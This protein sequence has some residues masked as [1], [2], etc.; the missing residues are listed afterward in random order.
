MTIRNCWAA[1]FGTWI[2]SSR[3][4]VILH[5]PSH[6]GLAIPQK[7]CGLWL[8]RTT[9]FYNSLNQNN[10]STLNKKTA[11]PIESVGRCRRTRDHTCRRKLR[12]VG[13]GAIKGRGSRV[14]D[15]A[16]DLQVRQA[17]RHG[18]CHRGRHQACQVPHTARFLFS[19]RSRSL[20]AGPVPVGLL[21]Q[22]R[23]VCIYY[24]AIKNPVKM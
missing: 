20:S 19:P 3:R 15:I 23:T 12:S 7:A 22:K 11:P 5:S 9:L 17:L 16:R 14:Q 8:K 2:A 1:V 24:P 4:R 10:L 6:Q 21:L 18:A 13:L